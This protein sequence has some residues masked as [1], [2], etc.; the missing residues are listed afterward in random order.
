MACYVDIL[1]TEHEK[2]RNNLDGQIDLFSLDSSVTSVAGF[3]YP[4]INEYSLREKLQLEKE[5][6]GMYFSG[7]LIDGYSLHIST[8]KSDRIS[9]ILDAFSESSN[10]SCASYKD[11][12]QVSIVGIITEKK[13]KTIFFFIT[14]TPL[15]YEFWNLIEGKNIWIYCSN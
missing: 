13:T 14:K 11:K 10:E 1:D 8:L 4:S 2:N 3:K 6:S 15:I 5:S 7:H 12:Q 9:D